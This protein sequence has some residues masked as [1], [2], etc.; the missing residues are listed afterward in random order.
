MPGR[1]PSGRYKRWRL[2][3]ASRRLVCRGLS[4]GEVDVDDDPAGWG[5][6]AR[7][8]CAECAS[9]KTAL[10]VIDT[11]RN[12]P[13]GNVATTECAFPYS[14]GC[15]MRFSVE[16]AFP[17]LR[18]RRPASRKTAFWPRLLTE[19]RTLSPTPHGKAH[20]ACVPSPKDVLCIPATAT[21][22][23]CNPGSAQRDP[24][25]ARPGETWRGERPSSCGGAT[26]PH[27]PSLPNSQRPASCA[28]KT[29]GSA[30]GIGLH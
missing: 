19:N 18:K 26:D 29:P 14:T 24:S 3:S 11:M 15:R 21:K 23:R 20:S 16:C 7:G 25:A 4:S 22:N 10:Y 17:H 1:F 30:L 5:S 28:S 13:F 6:S 8:G 27:P 2:V 9:R 12:A